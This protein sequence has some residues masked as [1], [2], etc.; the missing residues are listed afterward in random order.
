MPF[1]E[2]LA[3]NSLVDY[4]Y[5]LQQCGDDRGVGGQAEFDR[6]PTTY[7]YLHFDDN[8]LQ[9]RQHL[10]TISICKLLLAVAGRKFRPRG[11]TVKHRFSAK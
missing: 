9:L 3:I 11:G 7:Q 8:P 1:Q 2:N 4:V 10:N 6:G 5:H